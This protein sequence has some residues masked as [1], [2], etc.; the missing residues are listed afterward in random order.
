MLRREPAEQPKTD[1]STLEI[2]GFEALESIGSGGFS[3]VYKAKQ[4]GFDRYVAVKVLNVGLE[5]TAQRTS[6]ERE[7][8]ALGV[9]SQHPNIVTVFNAAFTNDGR[10]A[11]VMEYFGRGTLGELVKDHGPLSAEAGLSLG[12]QMAGALETAH[13]NG[14]VHRDIKPNN[15]F[16]SDFGQPALGDF[17]ISSF[18]DDRTITGAGGGLTVHYAPPELIEGDTATAASDVYSLAAT[19]FTLLAGRRPFPR[20]SHQSVG[21][22][23]RRILIEPAPRLPV[24][25]AP[26]GLA[27]VLQRAM[28]KDPGQRFESAAEFGEALREVQRAS[29]MPQTAMP[30]TVDA[31]GAGTIAASATAATPIVA[32]TSPTALAGEPVVATTPPSTSAPVVESDFRSGGALSATDGDDDAQTRTVARARVEKTAAVEGD[33]PPEA[34]APSLSMP[35]KRKL[36]GMVM[37]GV[38]VVAIVLAALIAS[39]GRDEAEGP[40]QTTTTELDEDAFFGAPEQPTGVVF[41][42]TAD[43]LVYEVTWN[44][45]TDGASYQVERLNSVDLPEDIPVVVEA[46]TAPAL[47]VLI[48]ADERPCV[49]VRAIGSNG[50]ISPDSDPACL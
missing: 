20:P 47:L 22:L 24:E 30:L 34:E 42:P 29:G 6:F 49:A 17:G 21:E 46:H 37:A 39:A 33:R 36:R 43:P 41:S 13:S 44:G 28:E 9:L 19:M 12:I 16:V 40:E 38:A 27:E 7:C 32:P 14:V 5:S 25:N 26:R 11:I 2:D 18:A 35:S 15:L 8:R 50:R 1:A 23:A 10:P 31:A 3:R 45:L 48:S 4:T